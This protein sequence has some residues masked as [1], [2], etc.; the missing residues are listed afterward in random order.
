MPVRLAISSARHALS[1]IVAAL[2]AVFA[3]A[4]P[5]PA[6]AVPV[7][8]SAADF[9]TYERQTSPGEV[10]L[11][12][13][14]AWDRESLAFDI[15]ANTHSA[16]LSKIRLARQLT[17]SVGGRS[18]EPDSAG[19]L[20]GHHARTRV[21]FR[22]PDRPESF[23]LVVRDVPDVP[24]R[25]LVWGLDEGPTESSSGSLVVVGGIAPAALAIVDPETLSIV[26]LVEDLQAVHGASVSADGRRAYALNM[27]DSAAAVTVIETETGAIRRVVSL[28]GPGHHAAVDPVRDRL[29]VAYGTMGLDEGAPRGVASVDPATGDVRVRPLDGTPFYVTVARD[30]STLYAAVVGTDR[31]VALGLPGLEVRGQVALSG[32]PSHVAISSDDRFLFVALTEGRVAKVETESLE[33]VAEVATA[34]DAHAV[35][36]AGD[37]ARLFV[38]NRGSGTIT[39]LDPESLERVADLELVELPIHLLASPSGTLLVSDGGR[40]ALVEVAPDD[41]RVIRRLDLPF[42]PH[43][44]ARSRP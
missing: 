38:A 36:L 10:T 2:A 28:P 12:V 44:S 14:P 42:Q 37:P 35:A 19:E 1:T 43:Q 30:G 4:G 6:D 21:T 8:G 29:Y 41:L 23:T 18:L 3:L 31:L 24:R 20:R 27:A 32:A 25:R 15:V 13:Q 9:A 26:H 40:R 11:E 7:Q 16:D 17:L 22:L 33:V 5:T 34:P 39:V